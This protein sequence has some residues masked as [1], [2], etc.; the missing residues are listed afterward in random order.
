MN[1]TDIFPL[2]LPAL[3]VEQ[4]LG[5]FFAVC[6]DSSILRKISYSIPAAAVNNREDDYGYS[7]NWSQRVTVESRLKDIG[8]YIKTATAAFPNSIILGANYNQDG[9]VEEDYDKRWRIHSGG[10]SLCCKLI[11][12]SSAKLASIIDGQHRL[13]AFDHAEGC[14]MPLLCTIYLDLPMPYHAFIFSTINFNQKK[15]DRSLAYNL[16]GFSLETE[17][18]SAWAPETFA[19]YIAR[20]LGSQSPSPFLNRIAIGV[21]DDES[22][23]ASWTV[24]MA[25]VV[26]GILKLISKNPKRDRDIVGQKTL[27]E[28]KNRKDLKFAKDDSPLRAIFIDGNDKAIFEI[29]QHYFSAVED[30]LWKNITEGSYIVKTVGIQALFD[31]LQKILIKNISLKNIKKEIDEKLILAKDIDFG[32]KFLTEASGKGRVR[33]KN[34]LLLSMYLIEEDDIRAVE[35]LPEYKRILLLNRNS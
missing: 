32:D 18:P 15:V 1:H 20:I 4:P 28:G 33:I 34:I 21:L 10:D 8:G 30:Y 9:L 26:D 12:P 35:D 16:F 3:K 11:I 27:G 31:V 19:V 6:I 25:T 29:I 7:V 17:P 22:K 13:F 2:E 24:S 14:S 5:T 23:K